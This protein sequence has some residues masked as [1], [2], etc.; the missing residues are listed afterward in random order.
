MPMYNLNTVKIIRK[1]QEVYGII[2]EMNQIMLQ[3]GVY[4]IPLK[5]QNLL[6]IKLVSQEN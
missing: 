5:A 6:I 4:I 3:E 2:T 1:Q